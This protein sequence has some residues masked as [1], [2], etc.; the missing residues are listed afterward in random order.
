MDTVGDERVLGTPEVGFSQLDRTLT[1]TDPTL[2]RRYTT[3][4]GRFDALIVEA[5]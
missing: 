4:T 3:A 2:S 1:G 5:P